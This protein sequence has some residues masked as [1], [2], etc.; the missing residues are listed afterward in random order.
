M[1]RISNAFLAGGSLCL[2]ILLWGCGGSDSDKP[3]PK[4]SGSSAAPPAPLIKK[5]EVADW[6]KEHGVPESI[7][8]RCN[9]ELIAGFKKKSDWCAKHELPESQCL[10]CHPEL[11]AKFKAMAP[12]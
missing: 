4:A 12:K 9:S 7:C 11:E 3:A 10:K 6:C 1:N 2:A 5:A 8:T